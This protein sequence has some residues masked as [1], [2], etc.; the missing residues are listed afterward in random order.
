[1]NRINRL[2]I[3]V[4]TLLTVLYSLPKLQAQQSNAAEDAFDQ[5]IARDYTHTQWFPNLAGP[6]L[7]PHI[8]PFQLANSQLLDELIQNGKMKL[9]LQDAIALAV[10]NNLNIAVA[11]Y[12]PQYAQADKVRAASG[13]ATRGI[14]GAFS[15]SALFSGALG[16]GIN[17]SSAGALTTGAGSATGSGNGIFNIGPIGSFDPVVGFEAG[18][19]YNVAPLSTATVYGIPVL[20]RNTTQYSGFLGQEF[21]TGTSYAVSLS[22]YRQSINSSAVLFNPETVAALSLGINQHLLNGFGYRANAKFIRIAANDIGISKDYFK[23]QVITT[24]AQI[25]T[26]YWVLV[27]DKQNVLVAQEAVTYAKKL[28]ADNKRQVQIGTLAPLDVIQA[29]S[30][31]AT[32]QQNLIVAQTTFQQQQEVIKTDISKQVSGEILTADIEPTDALPTPSPSDVPP[33]DEALTLAH[34]NRPEVDLNNLNLKNEAV[35][36]KAN[37]NSLLPTL[38]FFASYQPAALYGDRL[39]HAA[40]ANGLLGPVIGKVPGGIGQAFSQIFNNDYPS[41]SVG[42]SLQMPIR[43]R[44]AQADAAR[45][46]LEQ[47]MLRTQV[48]QTLNSIDLNVRQAV[49]AVVQGRARVDAAQKAVD[50]A[51]QQYVD[52]QKKFQV[53]ESTVTLVIQM[54]NNLTQAEGTLVQARAAYA[55]ALTQFQQATGTI[56]SKNNVQLVDALT[57]HMHRMPNIPGTPVTPLRSPK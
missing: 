51:R 32:A 23:E 42:L 10:E 54:Q 26:D 18:V 3:M 34:A 38:D 25:E 49:I 43:N 16:G 2:V 6:Y 29:E 22:G 28:L 33:L 20:S 19:G 11:R 21:P 4:M 13:Q 53:G 44:A 56:L 57:G 50:Y 14:Q 40:A 45:A 41:Y 5:T 55:T 52:E 31:L 27:E 35:V 24:I 17:T 48:Q 12:N 7:N 8:P 1:M 15:S 47:H 30:Q 46:L 39:L 36:L 9:S 37:R